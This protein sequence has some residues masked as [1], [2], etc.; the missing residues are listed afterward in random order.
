MYL[1][2]FSYQSKGSRIIISGYA[3]DVDEAHQFRELL[4]KQENFKETNFTIPN[5][6]QQKGV[7]FRASF[8]LEK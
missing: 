5:W 6:L 8:N 2:N 7:N 3:S 1:E 4:R